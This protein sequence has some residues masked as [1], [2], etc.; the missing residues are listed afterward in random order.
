M[1]KRSKFFDMTDIKTKDLIGE[2]A[3]TTVDADINTLLNE[4]IELEKQPEKESYHP[5]PSLEAKQ[6]AEANFA[7]A[8][9]TDEEKH[10]ETNSRKAYNI[11]LDLNTRV[12]MI[13]TFEYYGDK[14]LSFKSEVLSNSQAKA[15]YKAKEIFTHKIVLRKEG[16]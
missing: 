3:A 11:Y 8:M 10:A 1:S 16:V 15:M 9:R 6:K 13:D 5:Y 14:V 12:Y 4:V 2:D 7:K